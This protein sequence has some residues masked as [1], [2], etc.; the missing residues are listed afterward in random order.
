MK[1]KKNKLRLNKL[2][3]A[4]QGFYILVKCGLIITYVLS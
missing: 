3:S 1:Y 2:A 4:M